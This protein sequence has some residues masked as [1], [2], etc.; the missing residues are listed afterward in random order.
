MTNTSIPL[1]SIHCTTYNHAPYIRQCLD[2]F[3]MQKTTF[4]IEVLIHDDASTD[5]TADIIKEYENKYPDIIKPIYQTENQYSKGVKVSATFNYPRAKGKYIAICEGDDYWTDPLKLQKQV[6]FLESHPDYVMCSHN[7]QYYY[8]DSKSFKNF[9]NINK[10]FFYDLE[11]YISRNLWVTQPLTLMFRRSALELEKYIKYQNAKDVTLCY[12]ILKK[13]KGVLLN[14]LM[15]IYRVH[16]GGIWQGANRIMRIK[17]ELE[18]AVSIYYVDKDI[19]SAILTKNNMLQFGYYGIS[20]LRK[21]TKLYLKCIYAIYCK[22]GLK[23]AL[24][25]MNKT[26]N[27]FAR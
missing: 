24:S 7:F 6:D 9:Y 3:L 22:L 25:T 26:I 11:Y 4:P 27:Y 12:H 8:E 10:D 21:N 5:G 17:A 15:G 19:T 14:D 20:F 16:A 23:C 1:V 13:G 2:S 18:T